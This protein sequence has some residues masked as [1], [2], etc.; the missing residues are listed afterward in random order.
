MKTIIKTI[1]VL[2]A[3]FIST[4]PVF[5]QDIHEAAKEGYLEKVKMLLEKDPQLINTKDENGRTPLHWACRGVHMKV[6]EY[7]IKNGAE[8][9][10]KDSD[11]TTPLHTAAYYGHF[12]IAKLLV[13]KDADINAKDHKKFTPLH[14][15]GYDGFANVARLLIDNSAD[16]EVL[17]IRNRTPLILT[18]RESGDIEILSYLL[19]NGANI[20]AVDKYHDTA[21][22]LA[23]WRGFSDAVN[24][25]IKNGAEL[26]KNKTKLQSLMIIAADK[27]LDVLFYYLADKGVNINIKNNLE[28]TLLHSAAIGGSTNI[29]NFFIDKNFNINEGDR[30]GWTP[31]HYAAE[32]GRNEAIELLIKSGSDLNARTIMGQ[33]ALNI[34]EEHNYTESVKILIKNGADK[35]PLK[36]PVLKGEYFGQKAP[37]LEP[38]IFAPGIISAHYRFHSS[39]VFSSDGKEAFWRVSIPSRDSG[40]GSGKLMTSKIVNNNWT[41]P[42]VFLL[43]EKYR[44][45]VPFFHPDG[46][47]LFFIS[48]RPLK[49]GEQGGKENIW[50]V[51]KTDG[52][53]SA[54]KPIGQA[55]NS[56][57]MH[58][59]FSVDKYGNLL[60]SSDKG[61]YYSEFTNG[62]YQKPESIIDVFKNN[63]LD[64]ACPYISQKGDYLIFA[65]DSKS[66]SDYDLYISFRKNNRSWTDAISFGK[67]IN[68]KD[69]ELCPIV[70]PDGKYL[71]FL[72]K[73]VGYWVD[74]KIIEDLKPK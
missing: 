37:G 51:E 21:L 59:Q 29:I 12:E 28:G 44:G 8:I 32:K 4:T 18:A 11:D 50:Y 6:V 42:Q 38:I 70:S 22:T 33:T 14:Y 36:F 55:V 66:G 19:K 30:N 54:P 1:I 35:N 7:L 31:L 26:P 71:F 20:N 23:A 49:E 13:E 74:A 34:A 73:G 17:N 39:I 2:L 69:H 25:L 52:N 57:Q 24:L 9:D 63:T 53:W 43:N 67:T 58:W 15:T 16:I 72:R 48:R 61:I 10:S 41:Y 3:L 27:K 45:D 56:K 68:T 46:N 5:A 47:K 65:A 62:E 60:Y 64:G 40:Y